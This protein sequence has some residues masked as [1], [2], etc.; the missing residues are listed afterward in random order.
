M[1]EQERREAAAG[2]LLAVDGLIAEIILDA[3]ELESSIGV[4]IIERAGRAK[5]RLASALKL[6]GYDGPRRVDSRLFEKR[7][8]DETE[9]P[10]K[11]RR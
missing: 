10:I 11:D 1:S 9:D 8:S 4:Q 2:E 5:D 6:L 3:S 7:T